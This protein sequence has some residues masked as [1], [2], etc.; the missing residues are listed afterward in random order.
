M[1]GVD[2]AT[3]S[4]TINR[5][6]RRS[7]YSTNYA[8]ALRVNPNWLNIG[9][10]DMDAPSAATEVPYESYVFIPVYSVIASLGRGK[11]NEDEHVQVAGTHAFRREWI[12]KKGFDPKH[13]AV[14][15]GEGDSM[16]PTISEG[17]TLLVDLRQTKIMSGRVYAIADAEDHTRV[18]RLL[19]SLDGR[20]IVR[21]DNPDKR[22]YP[23]E[24]LTPDSNARVIG[25]VVHRSGP[26]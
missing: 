15:E 16:E 21:S 5:R 13:L 8:L 2:E 14:I 9:L 26:V 7:E 10:G 17:D 11:I 24:Y 20:I 23:D 12:E 4:A 22:L 1:T 18:K 25:M 3:I 6:S 19:K